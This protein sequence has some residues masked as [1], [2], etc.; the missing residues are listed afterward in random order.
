[1]NANHVVKESRISLATFC[2]NGQFSSFWAHVVNV[3]PDS[4]LTINQMEEN[5]QAW[6]KGV[7]SINKNAILAI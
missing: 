2:Y 5:W 3:L 4:L 7:G 1:V 6:G